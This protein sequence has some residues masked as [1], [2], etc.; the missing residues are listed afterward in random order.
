[1]TTGELPQTVDQI[2]NANTFENGSI[3]PANQQLFRLPFA[4]RGYIVCWL[5]RPRLRSAM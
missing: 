5:L 2:L 1:M 3:E 4:S